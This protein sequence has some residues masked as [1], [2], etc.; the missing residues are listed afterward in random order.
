MGLVGVDWISL[1]WD[2]GHWLCF[3]HDNEPASSISAGNILPS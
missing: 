3:E 1:Q 2:R